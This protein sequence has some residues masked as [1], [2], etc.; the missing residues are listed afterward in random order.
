MSRPWKKNPWPRVARDRRKS[1]LVGYYDHDHVERTK[2]FPK[3]GGV[4]GAGAWIG[5]YCAAERRGRDS[6]R[7]FLLDLDAKE[8]NSLDG[9]DGRTLGKVV[10]LYFSL[11]ADPALEGGLAPATFAGYRTTAN[12]HILGRSMQNHR[13][14]VLGRQSYAVWLAKQPAPAFN[15]PDLP[16]EWRQRMRG[17]GLP[18]TRIKESW[19]V[20]SAILS[21]AAG[22]HEI[23][24]IRTNGCLLANERSTNRRRSIRAATTGRGRSGRR[25]GGQIPS[26]A[27]S[28]QAVEAI[29]GEMLARACRERDPILGH[30][31]A[32][33]VSL[34]YG[35]ADRPQEVWGMQWLSVCEQFAEV[36]EV[37]SWGQLSPLGKTA[38]STERRC[39]MPAVLWR[40]LLEWRAALRAWGHPA[41]DVDFIIPGDLGGRRWGV[42]D[43]ATG[44]CHLS[45]NQCKK[46]GPKFLTPAVKKVAKRADF[47]TIEGA[48]PYSLRRGGISARLRAEDAQTIAEECGTSLRM[49]DQ[50]YAFAI[51]DLRRFGPAPL[52]DVWLAARR[53]APP[54]SETPQLQLAA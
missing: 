33:V 4:G 25:R 18:Q 3:A 36:V 40:D 32:M 47:A 13:H 30:R 50:H 49:L 38:H 26:W 2:T 24:E 34:Q 46:W 7:R 29:R 12:C 51:D 35:L 43:P 9:L 6:L 45:R 27:L 16:R 28:P 11:D 15:E 8:A 22:S 17:A 39:A 42:K 10:E 53:A 48:T 41:R 44:A 1:Y 23:P 14:E 20:L 52:N 54:A 21:W 19:K 37:T 31:D 5:D